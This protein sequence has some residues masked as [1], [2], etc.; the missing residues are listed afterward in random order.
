M[1]LRE[2]LL[3]FT[4]KIDRTVYGAWLDSNQTPHEVPTE[5]HHGWMLNYLRQNI[6]KEQLNQATNEH[7]MFDGVYQLGYQ[8]GFLRLIHPPMRKRPSSTIQI[9]GTPEAI[10]RATQTIMVSASQP[11]VKQIH[12]VK[13][14]RPGV[15]DYKAFQIPTENNELRS[16]LQGG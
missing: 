11:D 10:K 12:I 3:E 7:G 5:N 1:K 14:R 2:L 16:F 8:L 13:H 15:E 4:E 6:P 9:D